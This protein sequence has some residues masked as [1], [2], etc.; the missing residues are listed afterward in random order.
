ME[1]NVK[2]LREQKGW[3]QE[4]LSKESGVSRPIISA[5]ESG[6]DPTTTTKTLK[7]LAD[8]LGTTFQELFCN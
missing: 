2:F 7:A 5:I 3:S 4:Q 6:K 1:Y 8:A